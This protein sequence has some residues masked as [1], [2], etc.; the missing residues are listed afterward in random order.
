MRS[1]GNSP[2]ALKSK[3][4]LAG[5]FDFLDV[6]PEEVRALAWSWLYIFSVLSS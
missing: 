6:R 5:F 4:P 2:N 1:D 3:R